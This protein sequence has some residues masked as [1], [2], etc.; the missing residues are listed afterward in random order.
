LSERVDQS[1]CV[2]NRHLGV[3]CVS[4]NY[5]QV[6]EDCPDRLTEDQIE[7]VVRIVK[8]VYGIQDPEETD[9]GDGDGMTT[10][11]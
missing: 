9:N 10:D 7:E 11:P 8:D 6:I 2:C 4:A 1:V 3:R 5:Q